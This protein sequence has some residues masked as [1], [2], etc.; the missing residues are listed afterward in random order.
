MVAGAVV[1]LGGL[2]VGG[3]SLVIDDTDPGDEVALDASTSPPTEPSE[4]PPD[5]DV[6]DETDGADQPE[7]LT[8]GLDD[9]GDSEGDGDGQSE[10]SADD[11][12]STPSRPPYDGWVDPLSVGE[13]WSEEVEGV[14]TFRGSPTRSFHGQGPVP[15]DPIVE[16]RYPETG[17][18]CGESTVGGVARTW[19]GTGWTGQP[20]LW[21]RDGRTWV[22]FGAY[23]RRVHL[24][25]GDTG[26]QLFV[27]FDTGD[28]I[29]GSVTVDPDGYPLLYTG[30]R[31]DLY[32]II[33]FDGDELRELWR[34][35]ANDADGG[36]WNNDW[37]GSGLVIDDHLFEG[38]ENALLYVAELNR[39]YDAAGQVVVDPQIESVVPGYDQALLDAVG[40]NVSIESSVAISGDTVYFAN[41]GGLVQGWDADSLT[42]DGPPVQTFRYWVGD[43]TDAT[44]VV[45]EDG[46]LYVGVEYE[47]AT[48]RS[49]ELGQIIKLDPSRPDD[50]VV[51]S[52]RDDE[53]LDGGIWATGA[54]HRDLWIVPTNGGRVLGIDR[55]TGEVRWTLRLPGPL[56]SSPTVVDDVLI[57]GDCAGVLHA[58]DVAD[59]TTAP[60]ELWSIEL[61][62]CIES[63]PAVWDGRIVVGTRAGAIHSIVDR[64]RLSR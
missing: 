61:G 56:W 23:D 27:P 35:S 64:D 47:R 60:S 20:A 8:D 11:L 10:A 39:G 25:D 52:V 33:A 9:P 29:K 49:A 17:G 19:C 38:S 36:L 53:V 48:A 31:D 44:V 43:D 62:G 6:A 28:I 4:D 34:V 14:L 1:A 7:P 46:F 3:L 16:W 54:L 32:R 2:T 50:P 58:F 45:D 21:E 24:L 18:L 37:D 42:G 40:R 63:S 30:S 41:S 26:E 51:W 55:D 57:Q 12:A 13:P 22:A 15:S 5:A 59:T